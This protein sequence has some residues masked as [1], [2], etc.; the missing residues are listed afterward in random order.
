MTTLGNDGMFALLA[1]TYMFPG[2]SHFYGLSSILSL[3][4]GQLSHLTS[5]H[6]AYGDYVT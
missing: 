2:T 1:Y 5:I 3:C 4:G 6:E